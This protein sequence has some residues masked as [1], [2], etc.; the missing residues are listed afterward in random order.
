MYVVSTQVCKIH[1]LLGD[2]IVHATWIT[3]LKL[4]ISYV[5]GAVQEVNVLLRP[6]MQRFVIACIPYYYYV[7]ICGRFVVV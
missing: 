5:R 4:G 7:L 2:S 1:K 3:V 6:G